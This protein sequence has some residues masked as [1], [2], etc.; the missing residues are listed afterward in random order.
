MRN[1]VRARLRAGGPTVGCFMG[2]GSPNVAELLG[3]VG[4]DWLVI[5]TEHSGLDSAEV[6][7]MLMALSGSA[8]VPLVRVPP[9][10]PVSIQRALDLGAMGVVVPLVRS[11]D[12]AGE[13]VSATRFPPEG[14]RSFGPLRA[15]RYSLDYGE[16]LDSANENVLVVLILETAEAVTDL[17]AIAAT[18]GIDVLFL[19]LFDLCLSLGLEPRRLPLPE[20]DTVIERTLEIGR[21]HGIA[22]G[23]GARTPEELVSLRNRG[24]TFLAYATDYFLLLDAAQR[25]VEAFGRDSPG[26]RP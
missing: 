6:E 24:F 21:S 1:E 4:F 9:R 11:A 19:G 5:E 16:Y 22:I 13:V 14:R 23:M 20:I 26:R 3:H 17:E 8:S 12:E 10:D 7:H 18:P 25:G 2:L 15:A